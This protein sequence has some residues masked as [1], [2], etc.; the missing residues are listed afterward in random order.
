MAESVLH[1]DSATYYLPIGQAFVSHGSVNHS[2]G[3]YVR[4]G[5]STNR[6]EGFFVQLERSIDGT[7]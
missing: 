4:D 7:C 2:I 1:T 5:V 6:V 3:E